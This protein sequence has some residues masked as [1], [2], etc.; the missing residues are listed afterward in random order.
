MPARC[1]RG[2]ILVRRAGMEEV[3][4]VHELDVPDIEHH[5]QREALAR[6]LE[7]ADGFALRGGEGGDDMAVGE[8][9]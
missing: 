7:D 2:M 6:V 3:L 4:V 1:R 9:L 8:A 5:V